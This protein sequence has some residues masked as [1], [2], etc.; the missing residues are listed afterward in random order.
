MITTPLKQDIK[1]LNRAGLEAWLQARGEAVYRADQI[2]RWI[3]RDQADA[4]DAM[5][6][7]SKRLRA[8]LTEA[9]VIGRLT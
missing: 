2:W 1:D 5:T 9:F 8:A 3:Y 6:N 4:F 7:L